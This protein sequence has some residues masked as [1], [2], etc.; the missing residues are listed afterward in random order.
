MAIAGAGPNKNV[1]NGTIVMP[2]PKPANPLTKPPVTA[3]PAAR[4][5]SRVEKGRSTIAEVGKLGVK[6]AVPPDVNTTSNEGVCR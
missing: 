3:T 4:A 5:S 6:D 1:N 2:A